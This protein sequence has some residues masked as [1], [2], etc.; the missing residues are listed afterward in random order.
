MLT[1]CA[2]DYVTWKNEYPEGADRI[3]GVTVRRFANAAHA[4]HRGVQQVLGLDLQQPA[5]P[6]RRDGVAE[7]AGTVVPGADRVPAAAPPAVR[8]PD[9]LHVSVRADGARPRGRAR[10]G[11]SSCPTAHDEPAI[12]LEIFKDVFS[13]PAA[14]CYLTESERQFVAASSSP[15]ARCSRRSI[16]VGVDLPQQ[17][18]VPADAAAARRRRAGVGRMRRRAGRRR[19]RRSAGARVSRRTCSRAARSS[20]AATGCTARSRSTAAGSIPG[21]GCEELIEY[22][23]ELRRRRAATRRWR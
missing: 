14:L 19:R 16:G 17:Q 21:K 3:R 2:R 15:T 18:P 23:S 9:L 6:R 4:R 22:F 13:K 5:Q 1:T 8:R 11:A 20:A 12:R 7:A 10:R